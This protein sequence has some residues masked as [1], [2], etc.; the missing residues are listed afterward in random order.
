MTSC[1]LRCGIFRVQLLLVVAVVL[2][3]CTLCTGVVLHLVSMLSVEGMTEWILAAIGSF[4]RELG[5][6]RAN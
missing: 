4:V 2:C 5:L 1:S 6:N 3:M